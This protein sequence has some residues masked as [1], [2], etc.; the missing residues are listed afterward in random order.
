MTPNEVLRSEWLDGWR[1][2]GKMSEALFSRHKNRRAM[3]YPVVTNI[4]VTTLGVEEARSL[5]K[6]S[7]D[8]A[9]DWMRRE[10]VQFES[11]G[12]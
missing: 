10:P 5:D 2:G 9:A 1:A 4:C 11:I 6:D 7:H 3:T 8:D 12:F